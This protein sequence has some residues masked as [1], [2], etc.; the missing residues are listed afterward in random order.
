[1]TLWTRSAHIRLCR[2][3]LTTPEERSRG[4]PEPERKRGTEAYCPLAGK[5]YSR[6]PSAVAVDGVDIGAEFER[7]QVVLC[8][9]VTIG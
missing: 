4:L 5:Q 7:A 9:V 2:R 6:L 8:R 1:M 3:R